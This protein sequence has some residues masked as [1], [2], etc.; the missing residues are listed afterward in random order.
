MWAGRMELRTWDGGLHNTLE[1][2]GAEKHAASCRGK[3]IRGDFK[4]FKNHLFNL[5]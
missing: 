4:Y 3:G 1:G 2:F 5:I